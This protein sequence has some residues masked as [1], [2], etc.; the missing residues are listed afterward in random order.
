MLLSLRIARRYLFAKK[1][2]N[3]V[4]I[5]TGIA[6]L[7]IAV[8]SAALI[9][10]LSVF[11]GFDDLIAEMYSSFN[12]DIKITPAKGKTFELDSATI[13]QLQ[14]IDEVEALAQTL[15]EV[16]FFEYKNN[17]DFGIIKGVDENFRQVV[18][19]DSTVLEGEY[20]FK[21]G[22]RQTAVLGLGMRNKLAV[23]VGDRL[24]EMAIYLPK[25]E[26][27]RSPLEQ[28]FRRRFLYPGGTFVIQTD[29]DNQYV[30]TSLDFVR[31]ILGYDAALSALE[32]KLKAGSS[33]TIAIQKIQN[34]LGDTFEVKDRYKQEEAF[35]RLMQVEKWLSYAIVGL[36]LIIVLFNMIGALWM[37]VL[38]KQ[39]DIS[40]LKAMGALNATV[41]DI[42]LSEGLLLC[43]L[44]LIIGYVLAITLYILQIT[45]GL[46]TVP[47]NFI[48]EA[49]PISL[50]GGDFVVVAIT[51]LLIGLLASLAPALRA[52]RVPPMM[53]EE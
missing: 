43:F 42:F 22:V 14:A 17:Q 31:E 52:V 25:R 48:V 39:K 10:V 11:N 44:G 7:G 34:L 41:R 47:G 29:F 27:S 5:I 9:L 32:V 12:P 20:R 16:A 50:R 46:I 53:R 1:T 24:S 38:E 23:N 3:A 35:F 51:V 6:V 26:K 36:M 8:S 13:A 19:I 49:Y 18:N 40:I 33:T 37:M 30:L 2:T 4:N 21:D 28:P 45:V 15:E